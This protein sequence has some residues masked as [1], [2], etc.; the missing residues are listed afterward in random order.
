MILL[1]RSA[2]YN[3]TTLLACPLI[4]IR[5]LFVV[6]ATY[7]EVARYGSIVSLNASTIPPEIYSEGQILLSIE[8]T[9]P[10][11]VGANAVVIITLPAGK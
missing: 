4:K 3:I 7:F 6:H 11:T 10:R 2:F 1:I 8:V 5:Y 9:K